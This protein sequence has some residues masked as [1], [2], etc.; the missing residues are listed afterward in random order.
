MCLILRTSEI[1]WKKVS[2]YFVEVIGV[3]FYISFLFER[4]MIPVFRDFG[5]KPM[6]PE[7]LVVSIFGSM[8]PATM[9][10]LCGFFCLLHSWLNA[11]AEITRFADRMFY[12]VKAL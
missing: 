8:M 2:W 6:S 3:I 11:F 4:F 10:L 9:T 7:N 1:N 12:K 5:V